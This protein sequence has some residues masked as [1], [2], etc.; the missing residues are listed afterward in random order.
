M[1]LLPAS[2]KVVEYDLHIAETTV[3]PAGKSVPGLTI[4]GTIPGPV[5]RFTEGDWARIRVHNDLAHHTTS[6]HWHGVLL[7]NAQDGVPEVTTPSI[8]PGTFHTFEFP[9]IQSG[10]YWYHS[11]THLQ[12]QQGLYGTIVI[13]PKIHQP[14][15][16][17]P[18]VNTC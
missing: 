1:G 4:N 16:A 14:P 2:A 8:Q 13:Q 5:L 3:M 15:A 7:P 11:H 10:T 18:P 6:T 9:I 12:E 17:G